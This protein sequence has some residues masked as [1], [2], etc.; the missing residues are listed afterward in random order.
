[1]LHALWRFANLRSV[2]LLSGALVAILGI[3]GTFFYARKPQLVYEV[4]ANSP[5]L[6]VKESLSKLAIYYDK[7]DLAATHQNL[8]LIRLRVSNQ[9]SVAIL[10]SYFDKAAP[11]GFQISKGKILDD[12]IVSSDTYMTNNLHPSLRDERTVTFAP[13]I[14][15]PGDV[16]EVKVLILAA[17]S[18]QP[19]VV[20]VGKVAGISQIEL[21]KPYKDSREKA[22][23]SETFGGDL[24]VQAGR[25]L[26]YPI[27]ALL[28]ILASIASIV[29]PVIW[30]SEK[31]GKRRR[32]KIA[33]Q[34]RDAL[35]RHTSLQ[36]EFLI[37]EYIND[38]S[39]YIAFRYLLRPD[40][41]PLLD[42]LP[43]RKVHSDTSSA[44]SRIEIDAM[45]ENFEKQ[46]EEL[47]QVGLILR[48]GP[49][50][51]VSPDFAEQAAAFIDFV[52]PAPETATQ[53]KAA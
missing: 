41:N 40:T 7:T 53:A 39:V 22:Y 37:K 26:T 25:L 17:A 35:G 3:Y 36:E 31:V 33:K 29:L 16:F 44:D 21:K 2:K 46:Y 51:Q 19:S 8:H 45:Y 28:L 13:I 9:G 5:V 50:I 18:D 38:S 43:K 27:A 32:T 6:N 11:L 30:I 49:Q 4:L 20:P 15:N 23:I 42:H 47:Q 24:Y 34:F 14:L 48:D 1:M 12:S 10:K 52:E